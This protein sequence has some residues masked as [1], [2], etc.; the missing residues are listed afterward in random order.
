[1]VVGE[2]EVAGQDAVEVSLAENENVIQTL[3]PDRPS[4]NR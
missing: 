2:G 4:W 3:A 1:M